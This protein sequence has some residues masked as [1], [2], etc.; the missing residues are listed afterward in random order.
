[1]FI[2]QHDLISVDTVMD[3]LPPLNKS[4][5]IDE[6]KKKITSKAGKYAAESC[7]FRRELTKN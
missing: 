3:L 6:I 2:K 4:C 7:F 5:L 1:M